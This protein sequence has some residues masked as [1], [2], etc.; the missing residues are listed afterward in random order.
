MK[1]AERT[2]SQDRRGMSDMRRAHMGFDPRKYYLVKFPTMTDVARSIIDL[3]RRHPG[4]Q[5]GLGKRDIASATRRM[6]VR[7]KQ[8]Q[9]TAAD[10]HGQHLGFPR[11]FFRAYLVIPFGLEWAPGEFFRIWRGHLISTS[12]PLV[13]D[14]RDGTGCSAFSLYYIWTALS[15]RYGLAM[16]DSYAPPTYGEDYPIVCLGIRPSTA[17]GSVKKGDESMN[18]LFYGT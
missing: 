12:T 4:V 9:F 17:I 2:A 15:L 8:A 11:D 3:V 7:P 10:L 13:C 18:T 6:L 1:N 16:D 14:D 5:I